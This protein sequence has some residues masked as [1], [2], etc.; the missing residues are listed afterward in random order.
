MAVLAGGVEGLEGVEA[1][2]QEGRRDLRRQVAHPVDGGEVERRH[3]H[4]VR[5]A[6]GLEEGHQHVHGVAVGSGILDLDVDQPAPADVEDLLEHRDLGQRAPRARPR[7]SPVTGPSGVVRVVADRQRAVGGAVDVELH[8][9]GTDLE[10]PHHGGNG[11]LG[12][13]AVGAPVREHEHPAR[14]CHAGCREARKFL[15]SPLRATNEP[16]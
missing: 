6:P 2:R 12:R 9:V 10:R 4:R 5:P 1:E 8:A 16:Q 14:P 13:L 15:V 3:Q 11:V 7:V